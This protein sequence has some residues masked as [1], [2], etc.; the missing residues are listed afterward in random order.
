MQGLANALLEDYGGHLDATGQ[1][2]ARRIVAASK[3]MDQL[4]TDLLNYSR[5]GRGELHIQPIKLDE[6]I[7]EARRQ[8]E[9]ES[10]ENQVQF[11]LA[12]TP[13]VVFGQTAILVQVVFN[14]LANALKFV[15]PGSHPK[16]R[17]RF[18]DKD[19]WARLWVEDNGIGIAEE[20]QERIFQVFERLH[21]TAAYPGTGM[22]LAIVAKGIQRLGGRVGVDSAVG[23]GSRFW[24]ELPK[25]HSER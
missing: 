19:G 4:V 6:V 12:G 17:I 13:P 16:I 24:I 7:E 15:A 11:S 22:G 9:I 14:L 23:E 2:Y 21:T 3:R 20:D 1:D 5:L 10:G 25:A 8:L 18:E